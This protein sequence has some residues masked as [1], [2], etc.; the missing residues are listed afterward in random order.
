MRT[1]FS[2]VSLALIGSA[3][4]A[5]CSNWH[6]SEGTGSVTSGLNPAVWINTGSY[7]MHLQRTVRFLPVP[8]GSDPVHG[9]ELFGFAADLIHNDTTNALFQGPSVPFGGTVVSNGR[10]CFTCHRFEG[11]ANLGLPAPPV[12]AVIPLTD[13]L[14][15][16]IQADAQGDP[17][18]FINLDGHALVKYRPNRFNEFRPE[19]D[20][21]R[22]A[23]GWRKSI[24]L[25]NVAFGHGFLNDARGR[26]MFETDR[27][28]VFS[29]TQSS[30][31]RFDDLF[32]VADGND[33]QAFQFSFLTDPALGALLNSSDPN[34]QNLANNPFATVPVSTKAQE[35]GMDVFVKNCFGCHSTPNVF[36]N[37]DNVEP[38]GSG[39][40]PIT[41]PPFA[42]PTGRLFNVGV[43]ERN[44]LG[45]RFTQS[46]GGGQFA[47]I[48]V[49]LVNED[50]SVT[51]MT[52]TKD[53]G[54]AITTGRTLDAGR[55]KVPQL[56]NV[57]ANAPYFHDNSAASLGEVVDYFNSDAYNNSQDGSQ[58]PIHMNANQR[59]DLLEFLNIL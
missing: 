43:A 18:A 28:A 49:P 48:V 33:L 23:F 14:F 58:F 24:R 22:Q 45:L 19:S 30:D 59:A 16:G 40:R 1:T 39:Q 46:L 53:F 21:Y 27:G 50:G 6:P 10:S 35:H 3:A 44:K 42:P 47:P 25:F 37:L 12:S 29:H 41:N 54:L 9:R 31:N 11:G 20:P 13:A 36:N 2:I 5:A 26:T 7:N 51:N 15:T 55:F 4:V 17:D 52:V 56:R 32:S 8:P 38:Q 57:K 34:F